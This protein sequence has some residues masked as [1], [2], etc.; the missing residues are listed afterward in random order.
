MAR[1]RHHRT[2]DPEL[3]S[4]LRSG[5]FDLAVKAAV[6]SSGLSL[7]R[8][9]HHLSTRGI[10]VS[11]SSLSNWQ[12]GRSRPERPESVHAVRA[13]EEILG[14][15]PDALVQLL[16]PRKP[17]GRWLGHVPGSVPYGTLFDDHARLTR[18]MADAELV[19]R[20]RWSWLNVEDR[21]TFDSK[22]LLRGVQV[23]LTLSA[24][25]DGLDSCVV[26]Y[27]TDDGNHPEV[28]PVD[29]CRLGRARV[30]EESGYLVAELLFDQRLSRGDVHF[31]EFEQRFGGDLPRPEPGDHY[32]KA[33]RA[34]CRNYLMRVVF[35]V[36]AVPVRLRSFQTSKWGSEPTE[37]HALP[38]QRNRVVHLHAADVRPGIVGVEWEWV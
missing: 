12:T 30:D 36:D 24:L 27:R 32:Y 21:V 38:C 15:A 25:V 9:V 7:D 31:L 34:P 14:L 20:Q 29:G 4:V 6:R 11:A 1:V 8:L 10:Q 16:G 22:G 26:F 5:P 23:R 28:H 35:H 3:S 37:T 33:F 18:I 13:I 2:E 19:D 17:R